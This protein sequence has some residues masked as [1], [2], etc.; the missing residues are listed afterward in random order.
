M[1]TL[2]RY[3]VGNIVGNKFFFA[4]EKICCSPLPYK[5][6]RLRPLCTSKEKRCLFS[7]PWSQMKMTAVCNHFY[8]LDFENTQLRTRRYYAI[9][10][11]LI[12]K[13][14]YVGTRLHTIIQINIQTQGRYYREARGSLPHLNKKSFSGPDLKT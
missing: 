2:L 1:C 13:R 11:T 10:K 14:K 5:N 8:S 7:M 4:S 12:C 6:E 9:N 3:H